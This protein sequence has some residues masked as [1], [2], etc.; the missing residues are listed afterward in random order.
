MQRTA[1]PRS[2]CGSHPAEAWP[3]VRAGHRRASTLSPLWRGSASTANS[4]S[5]RA[6]IGVATGSRGLS[7]TPRKTVFER[8][9]TRGMLHSRP[10]DL[11]IGWIAISLQNALE[12]SQKP[13]WSIASTTWT[14]VEHH[15]S[16]VAAV[17]PEIRLVVLSLSVHR[18]RFHPPECSFR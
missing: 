4:S 5:I 14:E 10:T 1:L 13:P 17:L 16:S 15:S 3:F 12:L 18:L 9:P 7:D 8:A 6:T 2:C 11:I